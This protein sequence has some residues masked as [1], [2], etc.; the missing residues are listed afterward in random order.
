MY[1]LV[2]KVSQRRYR[3]FA[4]PIAPVVTNIIDKLYAASLANPMSYGTESQYYHLLFI[5]R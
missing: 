3:S 5:R 2:Y 1:A 4:R